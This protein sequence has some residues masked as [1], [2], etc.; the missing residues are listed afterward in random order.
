MAQSHFPSTRSLVI[1]TGW[2]DFTYVIIE[3]ASVY[4][5][6]MT[7][8]IVI[9]TFTCEFCIVDVWCRLKCQ[10]YQ[11]KLYLTR[12]MDMTLI[13]TTEYQYWHRLP[14]PSLLVFSGGC[15]VISNDPVVN[16]CIM[17]GLNYKRTRPC[18][19]KWLYTVDVLKVVLT[20]AVDTANTFRSRQSMKSAIR[21][22]LYPVYGL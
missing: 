11:W 9:S 14:P 2:H 21:K 18:K 6:L 13:S 8:Y 16:N 10:K 12:V 20:I 4:Q 3:Q 17:R 5:V 22:S 1:Y 19:S 15:H 7:S